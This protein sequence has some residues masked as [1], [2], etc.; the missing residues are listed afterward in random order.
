[1]AVN[2][3]YLLFIQDQLSMIED[4]ETKKMFGGIGFFKEGLMFAM[5]GK[6]TFRLK[7]DQTN[8][9]D[10]EAY[11]MA[12]LVS[13]TTKKRSMPYW[14][15]PEEIINDRIELAQWATKSFQIALQNKK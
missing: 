4:V 2:Q 3:E 9:A 11:G 13:N 10:F 8:Q 14:E 7:I 1:M 12:P 15:V 6:D 5:I